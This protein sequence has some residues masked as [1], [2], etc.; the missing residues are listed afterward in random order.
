MAR[1]HAQCGEASEADALR[2][3]LEEF[4][5]MFREHERAEEDLLKL[6]MR[7]EQVTD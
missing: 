5:E 4:L 7:R 6:A 3:D 2:V 1:I